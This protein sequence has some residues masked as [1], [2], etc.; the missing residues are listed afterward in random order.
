VCIA[1]KRKEIARGRVFI[2]WSGETC[3]IPGVSNNPPSPC[4]GVCRIDWTSG[5]CDGCKR[6]LNEIADWP[7][8]GPA[9]KRAILA[10][11]EKRT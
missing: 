1:A 5:H 10:K 11:T 2:A 7:M 6:T 8:L 3:L 9:Q 4:T